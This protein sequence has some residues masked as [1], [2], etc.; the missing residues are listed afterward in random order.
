MQIT[1]LALGAVN[2]PIMIATDAAAAATRMKTVLLISNL[3]PR[4]RQVRSLSAVR[5]AS[6]LRNT[7][8][9]AGAE[10]DEAGRQAVAQ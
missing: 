1:A 6:E 3:L 7:F 2:A 4:P 10:A 9:S 8:A 5:A